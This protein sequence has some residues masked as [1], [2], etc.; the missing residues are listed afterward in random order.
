MKDMPGLRYSNMHINIGQLSDNYY[1]NRNNPIVAPADLAMKDVD[2]LLGK[3]RG[4]RESGLTLG[5]K[6]YLETRYLENLHEF[7]RTRKSPIANRDGELSLFLDSYG[8]V[9]PSIMTTEKLGNIRESGYKMDA[10]VSGLGYRDRKEEYFTACES[11]QSIL[12]ALL[13][14]PFGAMGK[15]AEAAEGPRAMVEETNPHN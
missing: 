14:K 2:F 12:G 7:L 9:Y 13:K 15:R 4:E 11:Y 6:A 3:M 10:M 1:G 5:M 8:N